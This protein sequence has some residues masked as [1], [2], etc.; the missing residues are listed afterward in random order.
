MDGSSNTHDK[1]TILQLLAKEQAWGRRA[2]WLGTSNQG[3]K[4]FM[5]GH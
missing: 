5:K 1:I 2:K 3:H 4:T